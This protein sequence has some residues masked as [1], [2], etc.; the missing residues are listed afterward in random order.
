MAMVSADNKIDGGSPFASEE[1]KDDKQSQF[2][3]KILKK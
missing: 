3:V 2:A 1:I